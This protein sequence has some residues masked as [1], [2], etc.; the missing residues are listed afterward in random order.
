MTTPF[1][2]APLDP[3]YLG[4]AARVAV[5]VTGR[6][7][8][9][10]YGRA[11]GDRGRSRITSLAR[12]SFADAVPTV[13][14]LLLVGTLGPDLGTT[15][16]VLTTALLVGA[17][18]TVLASFLALGLTR[19]GRRLK[20][21]VIVG[22]NAGLVA[23]VAA[24]LTTLTAVL[25]LLALRAAL[26][27]MGIAVQRPLLVDVAPP[28]ARV[29]ALA[30]WRAA[31]VLG[32]AAAAG[33]AALAVGGPQWGWRAMLSV[34]GGIAAVLG[35]AVAF[36]DD[37]GVGGFER[38]RLARLVGDAAAPSAEPGRVG[39]SLDRAARTRAVRVSL[40]GYVG[41]GFAAFASLAAT[42]SL[43]QSL[44]FTAPAAYVG[45]ALAWTAAAGATLLAADG[46]EARRRRSPGTL[47]A[48]APV[49]LL[50]AA[51][52]L[53]TVGFSPNAIGALVG[54]SVAAAGAALAAAVLDTTALS[55][56][57]PVDRPAVSALTALST[58]G[59]GVL[60]LVWLAAAENRMSPGSALM[61]LAV[62]LLLCALATR[63][64]PRAADAGLEDQIAALALRAELNPPPDTADVPRWARS[65]DTTG[66]YRPQLPPALLAG[67]AYAAT[68]GATAQQA[69]QTQLAL[70]AGPSPLDPGVPL[71]SLLPA[72][73][74][75]EPPLV[76][77]HHLVLTGRLVEDPTPGLIEDPSLGLVV[78]A[79][80]VAAAAENQHPATNGPVNGTVVNGTVV[81]GAGANGH[82]RP[83]APTVDLLPGGPGASSSSIDPL[84]APMDQLGSYE[85]GAVWEY[86]LPGGGAGVPE[87]V[88][89]S[90]LEARGVSY[91]YGSVQV[92]FDVD[93]RVEEG[94]VVALLGPN[95]VGKTT[96]LRALSGL[97]RPSSGQVLLDGADVTRLGA[98]RRVPLGLSEIVGGQAVFGSMTIAENLR[99]Y[100]FTLGRDKA[101]VDAGTEAA[102]EVFP[103]LSERRNQLA[104]TLSGGEQQ[105]LGLSKALMLKPKVLLVDEFS[106]GL[107]PVVV[108][109]LMSLVRRLNAEGTA[110]L[111]VEQSVNVAL[112][113]AHRVYFMEKGRVV[114]EGLASE[115]RERPDLVAELTLGGHADR[116]AGATV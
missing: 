13:L 61:S 93:M 21:A 114:H 86:S 76:A 12:L 113:L 55:S 63:R 3:E 71:E 26:I 58:A 105:M 73:G 29:R 10:R 60:G 37:P 89:P 101:A 51:A 44:G 52:G 84:T 32:A 1:A 90:I 22:T 53:V 80:A 15:E 49:L 87:P 27:G 56:V 34:A 47:A 14:V 111:L 81:N 69:P 7:Q 48:A 110:I 59:G 68:F 45:L 79:A 103:R 40:T 74:T 19:S 4:H 64:L 70:P 36:V 20:V 25:A 18:I 33:L 98:S 82:G 77:P 112:S 88:R 30:R 109:E 104:S 17:L 16:P 24:Q 31:A 43:V 75:V 41:V 46:L 107:A 115:L 66:L 85:V 54:A 91:S 102:F 28:E 5:G 83:L 42:A 38:S 97:A 67:P 94:E 65:V 50:V 9:A 100:G 116:L 95:G 92:L 2:P 108:G 11:A 62:P 72:A 96:M 6:Q 8:V 23:V 106:L 35:L 39:P 99:M 57:E 78:S